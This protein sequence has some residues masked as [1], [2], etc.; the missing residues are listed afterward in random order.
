LKEHMVFKNIPSSSS[1]NICREIGITDG[2]KPIYPGESIILL[3]Y[4]QYIAT[5]NR[6]ALIDGSLQLT[7]SGLDSLTNRLSFQ[8]KEAGLE[9]GEPVGLFFRKSSDL[10]IAILAVL[11]VGGAFVYLDPSLPSE[12]LT[13]MIEDAALKRII[14]DGTFESSGFSGREI[15]FLNSASMPTVPGNISLSDHPEG[16]ERS[17]YIIY[18]SGSTGRPK[19]VIISHDN[20]YYFIDSVRQAL[21]LTPKDIYLHSASFQYALSIRQLF[22]PLLLGVPLVLADAICLQDPI[23]LFELI[24]SRRI[25]A[26]DLVPS[27]WRVF[28]NALTAM[29]TDRRNQLLDNDLHRIVS[30][31]EPLCSSI[32]ATWTHRFNHPARLYNIFGM[33]ETTG[34]ITCFHIEAHD[35]QG[36]SRR[37]PIG[38]PVALMSIKVLTPELQPVEEGKTGDLYIQ[39]KSLFQ[40]YLNRPE[41]TAGVFLSSR[42]SDS[43]ES[44]DGEP[45]PLFRTGDIVSLMPSG[46]Y[47][48]HGR[49]D[50]QVKTRG[51]RVELEEIETVLLQYPNVLECAVSV[52]EGD[53][54][55]KQ[56]H[57]FLVIQPDCDI[58]SCDIKEFLAEKLQQ[59]ML[60]VS[61]TYLDSLPR[62]ASGKI[63]RNALCPK[64]G[65]VFGKDKPTDEECLERKSSKKQFCQTNVVPL[66][67]EI[68]EQLLQVTP[69]QEDED[70]FKKGGYSLL[71]VQL[72]VDIEKRLGVKLPVSSLLVAKTI[73]QQ[74]TFICGESVGEEK[75]LLVP[76]KPGGK[77]PPLY[78]MHHADGG[79][80][81][82]RE[83]AACLDEDQPVYGIQSVSGD[84][85]VLSIDPSQAALTYCKE[86]LTLQPKGPYF[87]GGHSYGGKIAFEVARQ[88]ACINKSNNQTMTGSGVH[89]ILFDACAPD[90]VKLPPRKIAVYQ[91]HSMITK[92]IFHS[93]RLIKLPPVQ[94]KFYFIEKKKSLLLQLKS[95]RKLFR[96]RRKRKKGHFILSNSAQ[97]SVVLPKSAQVELFGGNIL[98]FRASIPMPV[99][100]RED[101]GWSRH[102]SE[103]VTIRTVKGE[104]GNI[105]K[106]SGARKI[107]RLLQ[108][109][110]DTKTPVI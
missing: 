19:G 45:L 28:N 61:F 22:V 85:P 86:I 75:S 77:K 43:F 3:F 102:C 78:L 99:R 27:Q 50:L 72:L 58:D 100:E 6:I 106:G 9:A 52:T 55:S 74:A 53:A 70:F 89:L 80:L 59:H 25:T 109:Y 104:H 71:G 24:R 39:G 8:I 33:S 12:R 15:E 34:M 44:V 1:I 48:F 20:L 76:I 17:A 11:K 41:M 32:P 108:H 42:P 103:A 83:L 31:G 95:L 46:N 64:C 67:R 38:R 60:P 96:S 65:H 40:G 63:D 79:V 21:P 105:I 94:W 7:Y 68:W 107:T 97:S 26:I 30:V 62:T 23:C 18:T 91:I 87:I 13:F 4:R 56:L 54:G 57:A 101:Y 69:V 82:Y 66:L 88:L 51:M 5:P 2:K 47:C 49:R 35:C 84:A 90:C 98:L 37:V 92:T 36:D 81:D 16:G 14:S 29:Q 93:S 73:R 110:I 10:I